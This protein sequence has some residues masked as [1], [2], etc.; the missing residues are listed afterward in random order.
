MKELCDFVVSPKARHG[1]RSDRAL[2]GLIYVRFVQIDNGCSACD[3]PQ[4]V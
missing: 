4:W 2:D 3:L 1:D